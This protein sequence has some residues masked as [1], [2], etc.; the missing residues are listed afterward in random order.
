VVYGLIESS[1]RRWISGISLKFSVNR[2]FCLSVG[3][4]SNTQMLQNC[5]TCE[6]FIAK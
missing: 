3:M 4:L 6:H 2:L 5:E 1:V